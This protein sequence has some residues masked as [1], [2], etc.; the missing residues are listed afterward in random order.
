MA[1]LGA[2]GHQV[3]PGMVVLDALGR[4]VGSGTAVLG[5]LARLET[6]QGRPRVQERASSNA[7]FDAARTK[8]DAKWALKAKKNKL[9]HAAPAGLSF[10]MCV[11]IPNFPTNSPNSDSI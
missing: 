3:G 2:L 6:L 4:Q 11:H 9:C 8:V 10:E 5:T 7:Q 1:V